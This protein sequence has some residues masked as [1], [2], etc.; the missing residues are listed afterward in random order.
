MNY[1]DDQDK[2]MYA[3]L[4]MQGGMVEEWAGTKID[5]REAAKKNEAINPFD[6]WDDFCNEVDCA[7][8]DPNPEDTAQ[9]KLKRMFQGS[10]TTE[11]YVVQFQTYEAQTGFDKKALIKAFKQNMNPRILEH[12][13][14]RESLPKSLLG[15]QNAAMEVE[16]QQ[17]ELQQFRGGGFRPQ[18]T[19]QQHLGG[20]QYPT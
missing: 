12:I 20:Q 3:L 16:H 6:D 10:R 1:A 2:I 14:N 9:T 8:G 15:W 7:F 13:Y 18:N 4:L 19:Y 17:R 5:Q 11:E